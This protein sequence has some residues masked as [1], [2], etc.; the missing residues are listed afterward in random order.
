MRLPPFSKTA[1]TV[2]AIVLGGI[3]FSCMRS[4]DTVDFNTEDKT[5]LQ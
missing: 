4:G 3:A 5:H 1:W 2:S